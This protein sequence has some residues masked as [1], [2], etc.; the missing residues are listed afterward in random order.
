MKAF[1]VM[2]RTDPSGHL[3][4][5]SV[6]PV[7]KRA[8]TLRKRLASFGRTASFME[9]PGAQNV[10]LQPCRRAGRNPAP[11]SCRYPTI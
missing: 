11:A 7:A 3:A 1:A 9:H 10:A 8:M 2:A 4:A 6:T 5:M